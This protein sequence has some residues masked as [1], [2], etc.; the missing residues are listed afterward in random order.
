MV[1]ITQKSYLRSEPTC[2]STHVIMRSM[3]SG[4]GTCL[5]FKEMLTK[6][7]IFDII[8]VKEEGC[9]ED[10]KAAVSLLISK[11]STNSIP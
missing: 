3:Y 8:S 4:A 1:L 7:N 6:G 2:C 9:V 11:C 5:E 10:M